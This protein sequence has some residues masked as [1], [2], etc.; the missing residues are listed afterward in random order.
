[1]VNRYFQRRPYEQ[2]LYVPPIDAI[3]EALKGAQERY[4]QNFMIAG[5]L[6]DY[7]LE[8]LPQDR[9]KANEIQNGIHSEVENIVKKYQGD[10]SQASKELMNLGFKIKSMYSP[11]TEAHAIY[12]N[13]SKYQDWLKRHQER[14]AKGEVLGADMSLANNYF[15][16]NYTGIGSLDPT[17]GSYNQLQLDELADYQDPD[18]IIR[19][20]YASFKPE[21]HKIGVTRTENGFVKHDTEEIEGIMPDR[22]YPSFSTALATSNKYMGYMGQ[23]AKY[24]GVPLDKVGAYVDAY[25]K[26]RAMDLSY[27]NTAKDSD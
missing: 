4:N 11:G 25:A 1:M 9:K 6:K 24:S 3:Q 7:Y 10:Y 20:V 19:D 14:V 13:Y 12:S 15:M 17:T 16:T 27:V 21:K 18:K 22:L 8:S 23:K 26:Q 5:Q 2:G